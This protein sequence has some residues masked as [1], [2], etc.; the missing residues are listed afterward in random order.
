[1][2][3]YQASVAL[4]WVISLHD[5]TSGWRHWRVSFS[6]LYDVFFHFLVLLP[7]SPCTICLNT[8]TQIPNLWAVLFEKM[9]RVDSINGGT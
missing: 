8:V 6:G 5:C 9:E 4:S 7:A 2:M 1:M 3:D